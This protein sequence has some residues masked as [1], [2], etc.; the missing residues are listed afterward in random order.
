M[1][2]LYAN[3]LINSYTVF[4]VLQLDNYANYFRTNRN[5]FRSADRRVYFY[6][7]TPRAG[8]SVSLRMCCWNHRGKCFILKDKKRQA[9][10]AT[11]LGLLLTDGRFD[12]QPQ[13]RISSMLS[14]FFFCL[15]PGRMPSNTS[16]R[17]QNLPFTNR[18]QSCRCVSS[19]E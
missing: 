13:H 14:V 19:I 15:S 5:R 3:D 6:N 2:F 16:I 12:S 7:M 8:Y 9:I 11:T 18:H 4:I 10:M 17:P 1:V